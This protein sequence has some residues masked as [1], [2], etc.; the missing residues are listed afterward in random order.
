MKKTISISSFILLMAL[1]NYSF[2][3]NT[4]TPGEN[5]KITTLIINASVTVVLVDNDRVQPEIAGKSVLNRLVTFTQHGDTLTID[6][7]KN[8]NMVDAGVVY[9]PASRL[10]NIRINSDATVR[11]LQTL[12]VPNLNV[13]INGACYVQVSNIGEL[14]LIETDKYMFEQNREVKPIPASI[15]K[16]RKY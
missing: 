13:V 2:G 15:V 10:Q 5:E 16:N 14:N 7:L 1:F 3:R 6:A 9:V 4:L 11:S 8:R 12:Q